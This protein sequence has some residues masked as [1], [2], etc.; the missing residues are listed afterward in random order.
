[1][2]SNL[3]DFEIHI[4]ST[5]YKVTEEGNKSEGDSFVK[6]RDGETI[7]FQQ[8][9][10]QSLSSASNIFCHRTLNL[11]RMQRAQNQLFYVI[12][13]SEAR[14]MKY[15][16]CIPTRGPILIKVSLAKFLLDFYL[17]SQRPLTLS[18]LNILRSTDIT[19]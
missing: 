13:T 2:A 18:N 19:T 3:K 1:M 17:T 10:S 14:N 16:E 4:T 12:S 15:F 9:V 6:N 5:E 7:K 8:T 11:C